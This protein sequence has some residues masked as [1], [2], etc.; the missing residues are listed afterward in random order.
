MQK[1]AAN[2]ITAKVGKNAVIIDSIIGWGTLSK[3]IL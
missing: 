3:L 1:Q 2:A